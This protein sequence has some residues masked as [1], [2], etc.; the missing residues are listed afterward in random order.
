MRHWREHPVSFLKTKHI[1][2]SQQALVFHDI[3]Y[4]MVTVRLLMKDY[5]RLAECLVPIGS[6]MSLNMDERVKLLQRHTRRF[7][8]EEIEQKFKTP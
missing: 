6:Q 3:D 2:A 4:L 7:S 1:Y 8:E 5:K